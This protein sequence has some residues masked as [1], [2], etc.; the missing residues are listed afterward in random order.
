MREEGQLVLQGLHPTLALLTALLGQTSSQDWD[1]GGSTLAPQSPALSQGLA[2]PNCSP[3]TVKH[4]EGSQHSTMWV[5]V[6]LPTPSWWPTASAR[7]SLLW[8][9][10]VPTAMG[11][12]LLPHPSTASKQLPLTQNH[13]WCLILFHFIPLLTACQSQKGLQVWP[14]SIP[15]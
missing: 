4:T 12:Q 7:H 6:P 8:N 5:T 14:C 2:T 11:F 10:L 9:L 1:C 3:K 15:S 13:F